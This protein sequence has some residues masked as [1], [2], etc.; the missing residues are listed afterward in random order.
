MK[1]FSSIWI[2]DTPES[3]YAGKL[4]VNKNLKNCE[5]IGIHSRFS[6]YPTIEKTFP[7]IVIISGPEP[8]AE[9]FFLSI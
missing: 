8:Y 9:Q 1:K 3:K 2:L 6:L 7:N 4:S 5:Y